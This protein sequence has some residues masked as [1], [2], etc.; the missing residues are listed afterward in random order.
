MSTPHAIDATAGYYQASL[1]LRM[2]RLALG[3]SQKVWPSLAVQ[4]AA[5][6]FMTPLPPRWLRRAPPWHA[7]WRIERWPF[8]NADLTVYAPAT[9][10]HA[11]LALLVHGWGGHGGQML[12]LAHSL[13]DHGLRPVLLEMPAHGRSQGRTS[14]LPQF[15]RA[16]EYAAGRLQQE[17]HRIGVLAAHSLG[18]SAAAYAAGRGLAV[19]KLVLV[20]PAASPRAYTHYFAH[21]FGL[22][23]ASRSEMQRRIEAREGVLMQ[24]FEPRSVGPRLRVPTLVV[25]DR[26]D[27]INRFADGQAFAQAI[28]GAQLAATEGLG[29]RKILQDAG[30]LGRVALFAGP[31]APA[32][33]RERA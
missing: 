23:E 19:D 8:E 22:T 14:S 27:R 20:A 30:V 15:A 28:P 12:A 31:G 32:A 6:L 9:A 7:H 18:A 17:G 4:A 16:I 10:P 5:R 13:A 1:G 21:V 26:G 25:H 33:R 2:F 11:P 24:Q 29:H 3:T